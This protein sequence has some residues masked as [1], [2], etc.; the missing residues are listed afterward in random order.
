MNTQN[1][2]KKQNKKQIVVDEK[3]KQLEKEER[4]NYQSRSWRVITQDGFYNW[5]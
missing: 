3:L 2:N 4:R 1:N 5:G